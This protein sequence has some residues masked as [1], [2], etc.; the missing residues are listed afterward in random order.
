MREKSE[1]S[2]GANARC[3]P[4]L[5]VSGRYLKNHRRGVPP[6]AVALSFAVGGRISLVSGRT[7]RA[8]PKTVSGDFLPV[9]SAVS[10]G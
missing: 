4:D 3:K 1:G 10:V 6:T 9:F 5:T 7:V 8:T 2:P